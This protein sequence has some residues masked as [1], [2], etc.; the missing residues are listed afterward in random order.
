MMI[1]YNKILLLVF[2][3]FLKNGTLK[4]D[5]HSDTMAIKSMK[6]SI[7]K[8]DIM[9]R[10]SEELKDFDA[11][12]GLRFGKEALKIALDINYKKGAASANRAIG[13]NYWRIGVY[14]AALEYFQNGLILY[15]ELN[16]SLYIGKSYN[17]IGLIFLT[18]NQYQKAIDNLNKSLYIAEKNENQKE[19]ARVLNNLGIVYYEAGKI[20]EAVQSHKK[21]L[22]YAEI[23]EDSILIGYNLCFLGKCYSKIKQFDM[24]ELFLEKSLNLFKPTNNPNNIAMVYNQY[25]FHYYHKKDYK[26]S[27][28]FG[29]KSYNIGKDIYS[30][31]IQ[32]EAAEYLYKS[33]NGLKN[34]KEAFEYLEKFKMFSD[35]LINE[36]NLREVAE[37]DANFHFNKKIKEIELEKEKEIYRNKLIAN[38]AIVT[39]FLLFIIAIIAIAFYRLRTRSNVALQQKNDQIST[40]NKRLRKA[41]VTKDKFFSILAHDLKNPLG[42]FREIAKMLVDNYD[43]FSE[44]ERKEFLQII[45]ESSSKVYSLLENLLEWSRSQRG[46]IKFK[47]IEAD[48]YNMASIAVE[49][50][51]LAADNKSIKINNIIPKETIVNAD[52][53]L[54]NTV[55]RNIISLELK[56]ALKIS[57]QPEKPEPAWV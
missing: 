16:D 10:T 44:E 13:L 15:E 17:N 51:S 53:N 1:K 54:I 49:I 24:A 4:A 43:M 57:E 12:T 46:Q 52:P 18:R 34:Y 11:E 39:A 7:D 27:I 20:N 8:V 38:A 42:N 32:M 41:N 50:S 5:I 47:P 21:G 6:N 14:E 3:L 56:A 35:T 36:K 33:Y 55:F 48:L 19:I 30:M 29:L 37:K 26:K 28:D 23:M 2:V 9:G 45:K 40:L 31:Y 22:K 25:A